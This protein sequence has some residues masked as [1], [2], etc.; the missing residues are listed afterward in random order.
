MA[1]FY[2]HAEISQQNKLLNISSMI[3]QKTE[4]ETNNGTKQ[5][6]VPK[7]FTLQ[8]S[9]INLINS[10]S[11][12]I[13]QKSVPNVGQFDSVKKAL[14]PTLP[15][16]ASNNSKLNSITLNDSK[17][18]MVIYKVEPSDIK[19]MKEKLPSILNLDLSNNGS[20]NFIEKSVITYRF[21]PNL[22]LRSLVNTFFIIVLIFKNIG[23]FT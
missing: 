6:T 11:C 21:I 19:D 13:N 22:Y 5:I 9:Q 12:A 14:T 23:F 20:K 17:A 4:A 10:N 1:I 7:L 15:A 2:S 16:S 8:N 3:S 18:N